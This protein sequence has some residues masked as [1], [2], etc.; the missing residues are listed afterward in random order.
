MIKFALAAA[1]SVGLAGAAFAGGNVSA[2]LNTGVAKP[3][4]FLA[5]DT[6]W[7]CTDKACLVRTMGADTDSWLECRKFAHVVGKVTS[8]GSLDDTKLAM[9]NAGAK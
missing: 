9:C 7:N 3:T 4:E 1:L 8:Y 2:A 5:G 6:L